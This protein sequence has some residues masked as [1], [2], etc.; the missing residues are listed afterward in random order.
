MRVVGLDHWVLTVA[1]IKRTV[2]F[3]QRVLGMVRQDFGEGR[4]ALRFGQQKINL[5]QHGQEFEPKALHPT[6]GSADLCFVIDESLDQAMAGVRK[7]GVA[8]EMGP[9][10]RTGACGP[11]TSFY[12]RDPDDNLIEIARYEP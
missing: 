11:I 4:V 5:H 3:Y 8:I 2:A 1:D 9:V 10:A 7:E 6:P 12:F